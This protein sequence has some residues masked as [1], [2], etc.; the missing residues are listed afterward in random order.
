MRYADWI[1]RLNYVLH[2]TAILP[3]QRIVL[4]AA[5]RKSRLVP[6]EVTL[7]GD[8]GA[9]LRLRAQ[10]RLYWEL[11]DKDRELLRQWDA[12]LAAKELKKVS[13]EDY[14]RSLLLSQRTR[15]AKRQ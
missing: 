15:G 8:A 9:P 3:E 11:N 1:C 6:V 7:I 5:M 14:Q 4:N 13:F 2:P 10:H 12:L